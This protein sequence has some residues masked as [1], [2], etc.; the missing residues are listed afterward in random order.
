MSESP[1]VP[2]PNMPGTW[3][4]S[5]LTCP[6]CHGITD[7]ST[8]AEGVA[9]PAEGDFS[10]C[11]HCGEPAVFA[12]SPSGAV[13]LRKLSTSE[14]VEFAVDHADPRTLIRQFQAKYPGRVGDQ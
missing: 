6:W 7:A 5:D 14:A 12:I 2:Q 10:V 3:R 11:F 8:H 9:A 4:H 13:S 1:F